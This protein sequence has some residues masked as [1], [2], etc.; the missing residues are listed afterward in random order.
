MATWI[1]PTGVDETV[2][3]IADAV[4][5]IATPIVAGLEKVVEVIDVVRPI[6]S[7]IDAVMSPSLFATLANAAVAQLDAF[8]ADLLASD[9]YWLPIA[10]L[11]WRRAM[12]P[13]PWAQAVGDLSLSLQDSLDPNRPQ[14]SDTAAWAA[15]S[16]IATAR[17]W[18][19]FLVVLEKLQTFFGDEVGKWQRLQDFRV[20]LRTDTTRR[21]LIARGSSSLAAWHFQAVR[22]GPIGEGISVS[23]K[24]GE[25]TFVHVS[26]RDNYPGR[27]GG[28]IEITIAP[29]DTVTD[30]FAMLVN[31]DEL[32]EL[33]QPTP[34]GF[35]GDKPPLFGRTFLGELGAH[36]LEGTPRDWSRA[37]L[38]ELIPGATEWIYAARAA[39]A[40]FR[41]MVGSYT[42]G[43]KDLEQ[44]LSSRLKFLKDLLDSIRQLATALQAWRTMLPSLRILVH[45]ADTGGTRRYLEELVGAGNPP[46]GEL[47]GGFTLLAGGPNAWAQVQLLGKLLGLELKRV[48]ASAG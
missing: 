40:D 11:E 43:L 19:D 37:N 10:P 15:I 46:G 24:L 22:E 23:C 32:M 29:E 12:R 36:A 28:H 27:Y 38:L 21:A 45:G 16:V 17:T 3:G 41:S 25:F 6:V 39:L 2:E 42:D 14:L 5:Y 33:V 1:T 7:A 47:V 20:K 4:D 35:L 18:A 26:E 8:F 30:V 44:L 9:C 31:N 34:L 13:Y 48:S